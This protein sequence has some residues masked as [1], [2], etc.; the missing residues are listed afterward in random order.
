MRACISLVLAGVVLSWQPKPL[1]SG[2]D[3]SAFDRSVRPQDDLYRFVN[4]KWLETTA[5]PT[6]RV[7]YGTFTEL[8]DRAELDTRRIIERLGGGGAEQQIRD[9]YASMLEEAHIEILGA[10]PIQPELDRI[11]AI[12]TP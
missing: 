9:L 8:A 3:L 5:I 1:R 12:D 6:D 7:T 2:L 11:S 4:G 10:A